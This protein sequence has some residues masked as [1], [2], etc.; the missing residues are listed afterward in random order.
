MVSYIMTTF[1][2]KGCTTIC[3][4]A[5]SCINQSINYFIVRLKVDQ[6]PT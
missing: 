4:Y 6:L 1:I 5:A 2:K 3:V